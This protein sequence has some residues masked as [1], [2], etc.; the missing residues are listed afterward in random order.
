MG[1]SAGGEAEGEAGGEVSYRPFVLM[2]PRARA[3]AVAV[4]ETRARMQAAV[5]E[6]ESQQAIPL[7]REK[8]ELAAFMEARGLVD[9]HATSQAHELADAL[10]QMVSLDREI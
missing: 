9:T 3:A 1:G 7:R 8:S 2:S 4:A 5:A 10:V 6:R